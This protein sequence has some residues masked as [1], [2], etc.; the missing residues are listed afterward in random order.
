M[1]QLAAR[2]IGM[3]H[4]QLNGGDPWQLAHRVSRLPALPRHQFWPRELLSV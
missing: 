3:L 1:R 4:K 2:Q